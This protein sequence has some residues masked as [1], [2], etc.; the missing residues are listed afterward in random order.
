MLLARCWPR[1]RRPPLLALG[2]LALLASA[3]GPAAP[4]AAQQPTRDTTKTAAPPKKVTEQ[5]EVVDTARITADTAARLPGAGGEPPVEELSVDAGPQ[6]RLSYF[7]YVTGGGGQGV[8]LAGRVRLWQPAE[9]A[10][11]VTSRGAL[12]LDAGANLESS[13]F[14]SVRFDAPLLKRGW[15]ATATL[16]ANRQGRF[17][18]YGLGNA[19]V[20]DEAL[21]NDAQPDFYRVARTRY[22][23]R[24]EVTRR[25]RGPLHAALLVGVERALFDA[26]Q[27]EGP[28]LF[29]GAVGA[30]ARETN[31]FARFA[32]VL[33]ARNNEYNPTRGLLAEAG[34]ETGSGGDGYHRGY[35]S[36]TGYLPLAEATLVAARLAGSAM[37]GTPGL[38][39]RFTLP[40]WEDPLTVYGGIHTNRAY[41]AGRFLG[42]HTLFGNLE[43]R[44]DVFSIGDLGFVSV[45]GFVEAGRVFEDEGFRLT[46]HGLHAGYGGGLA[47]RLLR[48]TV[49][50]LNVA[51]GSDD[52]K[53]TA[54]SGWAF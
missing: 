6:W 33:D 7:P 46:T 53:V 15:R 42:R 48:S 23:A 44:H 34:I 20:F 30:T 8:M 32:L 19:T 16:E 40:T 29:A 45:L 3:A 37:G 43:V 5:G 10:D 28:T 24:A 35:A 17:G 39:E 51:H 2:L 26:L 49:F 38:E 21:E 14:A 18:F 22:A 52:W 4:L 54:G 12:S 9:F 36:L 1:R 11:R 25:I 31:G 27:E 47:L 13:R 41:V 50:T